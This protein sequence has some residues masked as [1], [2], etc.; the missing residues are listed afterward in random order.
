MFFLRLGFDVVVA[1]PSPILSIAV[2]AMLFHLHGPRPVRNLG[3][4]AKRPGKR[5]YPTQER[6]PPPRLEDDA[7]LFAKRPSNQSSSD[8]DQRLSAFFFAALYFSW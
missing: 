5:G 2:D 3:R 8:T 1:A 6:V 4:V 7:L